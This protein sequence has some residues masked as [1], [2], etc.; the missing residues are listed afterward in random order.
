M[1]DNI[2]V[3]RAAAAQHDGRRPRGAKKKRE[4][5]KRVERMYASVGPSL[6]RERCPHAPMKQ[7]GRRAIV[8][9]APSLPLTPPLTCASRRLMTRRGCRSSRLTFRLLLQPRVARVSVD[10]AVRTVSPCSARGGALLSLRGVPAV[11]ALPPPGR[12]SAAA[13]CP[14]LGRQLQLRV[15]PPAPPQPTARAPPRRPTRRARPCLGR[16]RGGQTPPPPP[17]KWDVRP[18]DHLADPPPGEYLHVRHRR[19]PHIIDRRHCSPH[20]QSTR[21]VREEIA[22][23]RSFSRR[24]SR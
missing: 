7:A 21:P 2:I 13:G 24:P 1:L 3:K 15:L 12:P 14:R 5:S 11:G 19:M 18:A 8:G 22:G 23:E 16:W 20:R 4:H 9:T 10:A 17:G 6:F